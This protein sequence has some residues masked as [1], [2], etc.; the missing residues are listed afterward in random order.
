MNGTHKNVNFAHLA[1]LI[2]L[3]YLV[4]FETL[5][6]YVNTN[7]AFDVNYKITI[8]CIKLRW[9]LHKMAFM[10]LISFSVVWLLKL[11]KC[12]VQNGDFFYPYLWYDDI[13]IEVN[14]MTKSNCGITLIMEDYTVSQKTRHQTLG[15]NFTN[16]YPIFK[17]FS[18]TDSVVNLQLTHV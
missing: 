2:L 6:M 14:E 3:H 11:P 8:K 1:Q 9:Q 7:L 18:L 12:L 15:H 5:K 4:K 17:I 10:T 13:V 16:Y